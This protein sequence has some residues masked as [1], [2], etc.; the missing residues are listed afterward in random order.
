MNAE[1]VLVTEGRS[2][3]IALKDETITLGRLESNQLSFPRDTG[4]SR[5]HLVFEKDGQN[6]TVRDLGSTNGTYVNAHRLMETHVLKPGDRIAAG[7]QMIEFRLLATPNGPPPVLFDEDGQV[8]VSEDGPL[9]TDLEEVLGDKADPHKQFSSSL[10]GN[11]VVQALIHAGQ[12]L[13]SHQPLSDLFRT[14]LDLALSAVEAKRG[15]LLTVEGEELVIQAMRGDKF[16]IS[17]TVRDRVLQEKASL[18]VRDA[19]FDADLR[20][21]KSI[22]QWGVRSMMAVP[23]QTKDRVI[24]IIYVD[25]PQIFRTFSEQDLGLLTVMANVA[26]I[27]IEQA[28]LVEVEQVE[29]VMSRDLTQAAEIQRGLLPAEAPVVEGLEMTGHHIPCRT[30]GGDYYDFL[31]IGKGQ[32]ALIVGDVAGKGMPA[33]LMMTSLQARVQMLAENCCDPAALVATLNRNLC[34]RCPA[35]RF[36]S[37]FLAVLDP[38]KGLLRYCNAGHNPPLLVRQDGHV[39]QLEGGGLLLGIYSGAEYE[40]RELTLTPGDVLVLYSDGVT[41]ATRPSTDEEFGEERLGQI[42]CENRDQPLTQMVSRILERLVRWTEDAPFADDLTLL[43]A[44]WTGRA[45]EATGPQLIPRVAEL[46]PD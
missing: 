7:R 23:L 10:A 43:L 37:F 8:K 20:E 19:Q 9:V 41:E 21:A 45:L 17:T 16:R 27:R 11:R 30:V 2:R 44:R 39:Q 14:I 31:P 42:I 35:N 6:W 26:A 36:I 15:L 12:E 13:A 40:E 38:A 28:R 18:L 46:I 22:V 4:L 34:G 3:V 24:G 25:T 1:L 33:A 32:L 5:Q 29:R